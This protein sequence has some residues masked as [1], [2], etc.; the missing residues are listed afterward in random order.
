MSCEIINGQDVCTSWDE[1]RKEASSSGLVDGVA[2]FEIEVAS[3]VR[4]VASGLFHLPEDIA[5]Y[6]TGTDRF[7]GER[8]RWGEFGAHLTWEWNPVTRTMNAANS[9]VYGALDLFTFHAPNLI[10]ND[11]LNMDVPYFTPPP[12]NVRDAAAEVTMVAGILLGGRALRAMKGK[13]SPA[14]VR[15]AYAVSPFE[16]VVE[17]F[18]AVVRPIKEMYERLNETRA[19]KGLAPLD[20]GF[21]NFGLLESLI[22]KRVLTKVRFSESGAVE[23]VTLA[24]DTKIGGRVFKAGSRVGFSESGE[25][26]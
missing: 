25:L 17:D 13:T 10:F 6:T 14:P 16:S 12:N 20:A 8:N 15:P 1:A 11:A 22:E 26:L 19:A 18:R 24:A 5:K 3:G 7:L 4:D 9:M 2:N 21:A 23:F